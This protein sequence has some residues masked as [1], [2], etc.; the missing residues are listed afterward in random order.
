MLDSG[1]TEMEGPS[2][3]SRALPWESRGAQHEL[4]ARGVRPD[5]LSLGGDTAQGDPTVAR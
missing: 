3:S 1:D 2:G 5:A 4:W